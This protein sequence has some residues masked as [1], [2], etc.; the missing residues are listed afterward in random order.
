MSNRT[1][2]IE[3]IVHIKDETNFIDMVMTKQAFMITTLALQKTIRDS[4]LFGTNNYKMLE[5]NYE[6][7]YNSSEPLIELF[8]DHRK[9]LTDKFELAISYGIDV[10][11]DTTDILNKVTAFKMAYLKIVDKT[12]I[13]ELKD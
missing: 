5:R 12:K 13:K 10:A 11:N 7:L 8:E 9:K 3:T 6:R 2:W 4:I 1:D